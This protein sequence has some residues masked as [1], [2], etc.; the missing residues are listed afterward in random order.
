LLFPSGA[1]I[2][3][4]FFDKAYSQSILSRPAPTRAINCKLVALS[5]FLVDFESASDYDSLI[6]LNFSF[7]LFL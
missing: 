7:N 2:S 1:A 4:I 6:I 3:S 5:E